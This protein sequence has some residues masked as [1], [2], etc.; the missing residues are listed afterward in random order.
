VL[1]PLAVAAAALAVT[2]GDY[3]SAA[4]L[5]SPRL[6]IVATADLMSTTR[7]ARL[8]VT[9]DLGVHFA[10]IG[11][12]LA[13]ST[14]I[15]DAQFLDRRRGWFVA[16]SVLTVRSRLYRTDDGGR[17][18][19]SAEVASHG[20]HGG[21]RDTIQFV[22]ARHGWLVVEEPTASFASLYA[23]SDGGAHWR[24]V[25]RLPE[26][27]PVRFATRTVAWQGGLRLHRSSDGGRRWR[28][29]ALPV[30]GAASYG[31]PAFF[32]RA[33]LAPVTQRARLVV[34]RSGDGGRTWRAAA[35]L[36]VGRQPARCF[37]GPLSVSFAT[38]TAWWVA[39][40]GAVYRTADAGAT[41]RR[42]PIPR[43]SCLPEVQAADAGAA[44]VRAGSTLLVTRD[45]GAHWRA[46]R[47]HA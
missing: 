8:F 37:P 36:A 43:G 27:A 29:V 3:V 10:E 32:G 20:A 28:R 34:Y 40:N 44:W 35:T 16:W 46:V 18:W 26:V 6:G 15:D 38:P 22:D 30:S 11:P 14:A 9:R 12:P 2:G 25:T 24:Q 7:P 42:S 19:R 41:W 17:T 23:T 47:P 33:V 13:G 1:G 39:A 4:R 31:T 21:A 5:E 45:A